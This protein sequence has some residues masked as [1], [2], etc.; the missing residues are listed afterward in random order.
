MDMGSSGCLLYA[1]Q[2]DAASVPYADSWNCSQG[3][4]TGKASFLVFMLPL[5]TNSAEEGPLRASVPWR[6]AGSWRY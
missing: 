3:N 1:G 5:F 6:M 4:G 2:G